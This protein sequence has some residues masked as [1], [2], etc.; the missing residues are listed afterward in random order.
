[1][2]GHSQYIIYVSIWTSIQI[3]W[4]FAYGMRSP[5]VHLLYFH[6]ENINLSKLWVSQRKEWCTMWWTVSRRYQSQVASLE[7]VSPS[8]LWLL[9]RI[10]VWLLKWPLP[11]GRQ[12]SQWRDKDSK[13]PKKPSAQNRHCLQ[14]VQTKLEQSV[15]EQPINDWTKLRPIPWAR[16]N[17]WHS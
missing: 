2:R 17:P 1:V 15:R 13:P 3:K 7:I 10:L 14:D 9:I 16:T 4:I 11:V 6:R 12:D 8:A 5:M